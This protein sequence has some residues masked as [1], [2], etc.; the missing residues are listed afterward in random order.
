[1]EIVRL[2]VDLENRVLRRTAQLE[3]ASKEM[4]AFSYSV[5]HD[6]RTP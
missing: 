4:E 1:M 5:A 6:L 3:A 2:N